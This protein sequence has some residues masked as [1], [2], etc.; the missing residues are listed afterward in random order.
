MISRRILI[1][2]GLALGAAAPALAKQPATW[3]EAAF[4]AAKAAGKPILLEIHAVWCPTCKAQ[5]PILSELTSEPKYADLQVF[6][7]DFDTEKDLLK[8]LNVRTQ[9]TLIV[10]KQGAEVGRSVGDTNRDSIAELLSKTI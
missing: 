2:S 9:S 8:K 4:D 5:T 6:K 1:L 10:Y 3:N 7:I